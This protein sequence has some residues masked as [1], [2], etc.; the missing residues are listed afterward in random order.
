MKALHKALIVA[1][2]TLLFSNVCSAQEA[3]APVLSFLNL[4]AE[5]KRDVAAELAEGNVTQDKGVAGSVDG[6]PHSGQ[7]DRRI[8]DGKDE[9]SISDAFRTIQ[10]CSFHKAGFVSPLPDERT[11]W[12]YYRC[13]EAVAVIFYVSPSGSPGKVKMRDLA[14]YLITAHGLMGWDDNRFRSSNH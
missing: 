2:S 11:A 10:A 13:P 4:L 5:N 1:S 14:Q 3:A 8:V 6:G 12:V 9:I 7:W